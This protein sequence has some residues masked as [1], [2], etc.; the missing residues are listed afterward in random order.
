MPSWITKKMQNGRIYAYIKE[1]KFFLERMDSV[2]RAYILALATL[3]RRSELFSAKPPLLKML[4]RPLDYSRDEL[5]QGFYDIEDLLFANTK[6]LEHTKRIMQTTG[7]KLP[8]FAQ[9][10]AEMFGIGMKV[11][12]CT[13]GAGIVPQHRDD[14]T[15]IWSLLA[16]SK[17][18]LGEAL[19]R[20][21]DLEGRIASETSM[22]GNVF[23][24]IDINEWIGACDFVPAALK[25][26]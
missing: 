8:Q 5:L 1:V 26:K 24:D 25:A 21:H 16:N 3:Q 7:E 14:V 23:S 4:D 2:G 6:Q 20:L 22:P 18:Y 11:W 9:I 17:E 19:Q 10:H 15:R 12:I 13:L